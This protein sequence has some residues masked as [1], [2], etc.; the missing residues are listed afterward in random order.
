V[1]DHVRRYAA[2]DVVSREGDTDAGWFVLRTGRV[3]VFKGDVQIDVFHDPGT[4]F[5]ELSGI[6]QRPRTASL[7]AL[8]DS[9]LL[10]L[11]ASLDEL[12]ARHPG[13][14]RTIVQTLAERLARTT[15]ELWVRAR[16]G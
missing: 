7:V 15:D 8:E 4:V 14:V 16:G 11:T 5:G 13:V 3:G 12:I 1:D 2:G 9:E 6:L 10:Y